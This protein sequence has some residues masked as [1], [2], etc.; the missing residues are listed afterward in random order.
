MESQP[1][2]PDRRAGC[3]NQG[4]VPDGQYPAMF[5]QGCRQQFMQQY[6]Q[7]HQGFGP[8]DKVGVFTA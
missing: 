7:L 5:V 2:R 8:G 3:K 4:F 1:G 6:L